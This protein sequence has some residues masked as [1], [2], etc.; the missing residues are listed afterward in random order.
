MAPNAVIWYRLL[1]TSLAQARGGGPPIHC[2]CGREQKISIRADPQ[3]A[4]RRSICHESKH[5]DYITFT[6]SDPPIAQQMGDD[7]TSR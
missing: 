5:P 6:W 3:T 2:A 7:A 1:H 4:Q